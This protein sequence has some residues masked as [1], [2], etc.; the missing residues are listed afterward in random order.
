MTGSVDLST[1]LQDWARLAGMDLV[2]G[3][4]TQ[5]GRTV[6]WNKGGE[7]RYF[8]NLTDSYY[9]ITMSDRTSPEYF[10]FAAP[11]M[12]LIEKYLYGRFGGSVRKAHGLKRLQKPFTRDELKQGY[13]FGKITFADRER[14][15]LIDRDGSTAAIAAD[16]RLVEMSH[17][18]DVPV[19]TIKNSF[20]DPA[21]K[22]LFVVLG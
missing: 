22:P 17:Y 14:E 1:G 3:S 15:T 12:E 21:G 6:L 20:L 16:D 4:R 8:I 2:Q 10:N 11:T 9:V 13:S 5:D 18:V 7:I 19:E